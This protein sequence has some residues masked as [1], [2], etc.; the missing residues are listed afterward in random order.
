MATAAAILAFVSVGLGT[1]F[2]VMIVQE[3]S[4]R[5]VKI[6]YVLI[7]MYIYRYIAQY[8]QLTLKETG[9]VGPLYYPCV[10]SYVAALVFA[11]VYLIAR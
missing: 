4:K 5:G 9:Q 1:V 2:S 10:G 3:V 8:K 11:I 6:H 7:R